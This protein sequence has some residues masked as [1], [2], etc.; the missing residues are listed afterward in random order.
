MD[1]EIVKLKNLWMHVILNAIADSIGTVKAPKIDKDK[2]VNRRRDWSYA[3]RMLI[4]G[5]AKFYLESNSYR[6]YG[7]LWVCDIC[8]L[9]AENVRKCVEGK[10]NFK[11]YHDE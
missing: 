8:G 7:F 11:G 10:S 5:N 2:E 6:K 9:D 1:P 4:K 3:E